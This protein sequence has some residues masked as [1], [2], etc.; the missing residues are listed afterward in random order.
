MEN[1]SEIYKSKIC[2][3]CTKRDTCTKDKFKRYEI[4]DKISTRCLEYKY[5][6]A[7]KE[8]FIVY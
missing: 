2:V 8:E 5:E 6:F 1:D 7:N 4:G 3:L